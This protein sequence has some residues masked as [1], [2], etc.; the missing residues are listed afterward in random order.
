MTEHE[1]DTWL[2]KRHWMVAHWPVDENGELDDHGQWRMGML[3]AD[4]EKE[5]IEQLAH[6]MPPFASPFR[7]WIIE[8]TKENSRIGNLLTMTS[9]EGFI[10]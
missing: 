8:I 7:I 3:H 5:L 2:S 1:H 10:D 9:L 4:T 6:Q